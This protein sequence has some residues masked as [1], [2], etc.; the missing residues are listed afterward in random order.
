[1]TFG[2]GVGT[3]TVSDLAGDAGTFPG[4]LLE[5]LVTHKMRFASQGA[6]RVSRNRSELSE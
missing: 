2:H 5:T 1:V 6:V 3:R 4:A